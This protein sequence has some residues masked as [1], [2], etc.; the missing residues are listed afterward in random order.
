MHQENHFSFGYLAEFENGKRPYTGQILH[1]NLTTR[2]C[3]LDQP[4]EGFYRSL[5]GGRGFIL[6]YL[7]TQTEPGIDP[8]SPENLL[9]FAPGILTGTVLP[10]TGRHAV[11]A[12]SPL[13]GA[14]ASSEAGGWFG[15][16]I[17]RAGLDALIIHGKALEPVYLWI[18]DGVLEV[19][20]ADHLWGGLTADVQAKIRNELEDEQ[21]RI[22]QIGPAGENLVRYANIM[23]DVNRAAGRS[24]LGAVMGSKNLKAVAV[25]GGK[26]ISVANREKL[27]ETLKWMTTT[28]TDSMGWAISYGTAGS[29]KA[30]HDSGTTGIRNYQDGFLEG[31]D[32]LAH[33]NFFPKFVKDRDTCSHCAVK[34]KLVVDYQDEETEIKGVYG[35]PEYES[36]GGLGPLCAVADPV[37][38][39]KANEQCAA[40]GLDTIST[41]GTI[42][43]TMECQEKGLLGDYSFQPRFGNGDDLVEAI[44][45]IAYRDGLGDLM[46]E[47]SLRISNM[48][49]PQSRAFLAEARGQEF[50]LH[51]PRFKNTTGMG[52]ALSATGADHMHNIIDNFANFAGSDICAR[53]NEMGM[54][55]PLPL[56]GISDQKVQGYIYETAFKNVLDSAVIC[57]FYPYEYR[58]IVEALSAAAD[59]D[60]TKEEINQ[61]GTRIINMARLYLLR[62]G[63]THE[64]DRISERAFYALKDGPIAGRTLDQDELSNAMQVYFEKMGWD[65]E[66]VPSIE[67]ISELKIAEYVK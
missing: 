20:S 1:I 24:G 48:I 61:I 29:V 46:A 8:L 16:E 5:I 3:W 32:N 59:W 55:T 37:A 23:H 30:N 53:L 50:P 56:F 10:G 51:D 45:K 63:F 58:H 36:F 66:G 57:H 62:E 18:N 65:Q 33:D 31:I 15:H 43:F 14:L 7:L 4:A 11:G 19:R 42:A 47:G 41:G 6:H 12:K 17:K 25:R 22:A 54:D 38:V 64:D 27:K 9:I 49:N 34:C 26:R 39:A 67:V 2:A 40:F 28:Y 35:G 60:I 44:R 21:I 52:Y 13:T